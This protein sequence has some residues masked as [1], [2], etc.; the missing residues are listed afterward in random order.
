[1]RFFFG[2]QESRNSTHAAVITIWEV[3]EVAQAEVRLITGDAELLLGLWPI[4]KLELE[5]DFER[6]NFQV[7][8]G[9]WNSTVRNIQ[10]R[11]VFPLAPMAIGRS[12]LGG[13]F[14]KMGSREIAVLAAHAASGGDFEEQMISK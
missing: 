7:G 9:A 12:E 1:M 14:A 8:Q 11:W 2:G 4:G 10:N 6:S 3:A 5:V 13:Y